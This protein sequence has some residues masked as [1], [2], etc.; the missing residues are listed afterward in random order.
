MTVAL[1]ASLADYKKSK[2]EL[3]QMDQKNIC[4]SSFDK[5]CIGFARAAD[6]RGG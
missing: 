2:K 1:K 5:T 4:S 6:L 3:L